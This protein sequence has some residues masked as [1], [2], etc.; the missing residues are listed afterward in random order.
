MPQRLL[1]RLRFKIHGHESEIAWNRDADFLQACPFPCLRRRAIDF[2]HVQFL[3][4]G[5]RVSVGEVL[6]P[7]PKYYVLAYAVSN[8]QGEFVL[9]V[10]TAHGHESPQ[11]GR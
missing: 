8:A 9:G 11:V 5:V 2:E 7:V 3:A 1:G 10:S 6:S 4:L